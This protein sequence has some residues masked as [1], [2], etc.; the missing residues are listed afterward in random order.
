MLRGWELIRLM[1]RE[2]A[3][4]MLYTW[5]E[6]FQIG[7]IQRTKPLRLYAGRPQWKALPI[8]GF[9]HEIRQFCS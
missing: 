7:R 5:S 8:T 2:T 1:G 9:N 6:R 3:T 4:T